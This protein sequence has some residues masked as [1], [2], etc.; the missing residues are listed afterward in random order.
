MNFENTVGVSFNRTSEF[1][2]DHVRLKTT[3]EMNIRAES[4]GN[5][6]EDIQSL[7]NDQSEEGIGNFYQD[8]SINGVSMGEG[9]VRS[10]NA[11][12]N[13]TDTQKKTYTA[14]IV[15]SKEGNLDEILPSVTKE[16]S[17]YIDSISESFSREQS[18]HR[19]T[20]S[21]TC[22]VQL[23]P[24]ERSEGF[25]SADAILSGILE[26]Q[27]YLTSL[28]D[29]ESKD[30]YK[31]KN[32]SFDESSNSYNYEETREYVENELS[33]DKN[34]V[35]KTGS[36]NYTNGNIIAT[37]SA[38]ITGISVEEE[39]RRQ[40]ALEKAV[41]L[42][43]SSA[44]YLFDNYSGSIPGTHETLKSTPINKTLTFNR[45]EAK[46]TVAVVYSNSLDMMEEEVYWEYTS[47]TQILADEIIISENGNI[48]GGNIIDIINNGTVGESRKYN[49]VESFFNSTCNI[50]SVKSRVNG[51]IPISESISRN[52]TNGSI[53]Y[54]YSFSNNGSLNYSSADDVDTPDR[55]IVKSL[56][57]QKDLTLHSTFVI[58]EFKEL[59][60]AQP[61]L[62][63]K[64]NTVKNNI[65]T[66]S[67]ATI[68]SFLGYVEN[69]SDNYVIDSIT[70][71]FSPKKR[72]F[73]SET[74]YFEILDGES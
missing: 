17:K 46:C 68:D 51:V 21:H 69:P 70:F 23:N 2:G 60:Q 47:E 7:I 8:I 52:Y 12:P 54:N 26:E 15:I 55:K 16:D 28:F 66:N 39:S 11:D 33:D 32:Y 35:I 25:S 1:A 29:I 36:F 48:I 72:E 13:G 27:S 45:N 20:I 30:V 31:I 5:S 37:F 19:F 14:T 22:S 73:S 58:P 24:K 74:S 61:N 10:I 3:L 56:N 71:Q 67:T 64:L 43:S 38:E 41:E 62:L 40:D 57:L 18:S 9:Y 53:R 42:L 44:Q 50:D 4:I 59:L 63:P 34:I 65:S 49:L 6:P